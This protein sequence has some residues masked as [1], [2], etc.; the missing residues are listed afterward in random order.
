MEKTVKV[1]SLREETYNKIM[2]SCDFTRCKDSLQAVNKMFMGCWPTM[3]RLMIDNEVI[4]DDNAII[5]KRYADLDEKYKLLVIKYDKL[6]ESIGIDLQ[7]EGEKE[8]RP[9]S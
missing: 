7:K 8:A 2:A 6:K 5:L 3:E 4:L 9:C 1:S